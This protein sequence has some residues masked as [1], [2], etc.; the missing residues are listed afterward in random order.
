M[1]QPFI[2]ASLA[3]AHWTRTR[4]L[5]F[6]I[7]VHAGCRGSGGA[8]RTCKKYKMSSGRAAAQGGSDL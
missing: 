2:I 8:V 3:Q 4:K 6:F 7:L 5:R 1:T